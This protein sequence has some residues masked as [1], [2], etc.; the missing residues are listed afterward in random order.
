MRVMI[1]C[2]PL[3]R[4]ILNDETTA[5]IF[6]SLKRLEWINPDW[7]RIYFTD[8]SNSHP[9][10]GWM[11][12]K[13]L[14][15]L[16]TFGGTLGWK[17]WYQ[18]QLPAVVKKE[19]ANLLF[20]TGGIAAKTSIPQC[21]WVPFSERLSVVTNRSYYRLF[22][23]KFSSS[24]SLPSCHFLVSAKNAEL[25]SGKNKS[26]T[27]RLHI[28]NTPSSG[29]QFA[30]GWTDRENTKVRYSGGRD[31]FLLL[32]EDNYRLPAVLEILKGFSLFKKWQE[33]NLQLVIT[34]KKISAD[35]SLLEKL[36]SY[37]YRSDVHLIGKA[38]GEEW[39]RLLGSAYAFLYPFDED[40]FA[41]PAVQAFDF[42]VPVIG[43]ESGG[44]AAAYSSAA[45]F[46]QDANAESWS[47]QMIAVYKDEVLRNRLIENGK[48]EVMQNSWDSCTQIIW[49]AAESA[50]K[51]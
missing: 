41:M 37:K 48:K 30:P 39:N 15:V 22:K 28:L 29:N 10:A 42:S 2:R 31:F 32:A 7:Q 43:S 34:G 25:I 4:R 14:H 47:K 17:Y 40:G 6:E 36:E 16:K 20:T 38:T 24:L 27:N 26:V 8:S 9:A 49:N 1:D 19:Q 5:F 3:F 21:T 50:R 18:H 46:A 44:L 23:K 11:E 45:I 12:P 51:N 35:F 13:H 33:S